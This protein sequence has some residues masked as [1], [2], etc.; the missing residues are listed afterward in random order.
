MYRALHHESYPKQQSQAEISGGKDVQVDEV[1]YGQTGSV[2][3]RK[4]QHTK[5]SLFKEMEEAIRYL[6][7]DGL[8][9]KGKRTSF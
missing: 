1:L 3:K 6:E 8:V 9:A 4:K 5:E 7:V 2:P